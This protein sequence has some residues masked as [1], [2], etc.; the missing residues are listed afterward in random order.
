M[1]SEPETLCNFPHIWKNIGT[2]T[3]IS[4]YNSVS[5]HRDKVNG[6]QRAVIWMGVSASAGISDVDCINLETIRSC[7]NFCRLDLVTLI[8]VCYG[9]RCVPSEKVNK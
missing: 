2:L 5:G 7:L 1:K 8:S 6:N 3:S 9:W 4:F